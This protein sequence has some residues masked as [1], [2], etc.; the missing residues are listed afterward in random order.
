M[1]CENI[2]LANIFAIFSKC[3]NQLRN[4]VLG[5][6]HLSRGFKCHAQDMNYTDYITKEEHVVTV[7]R[8]NNQ[9]EVLTI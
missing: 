7:G 8:L 3:L 4:I 6:E 1:F 9:L 2:Y 5:Y